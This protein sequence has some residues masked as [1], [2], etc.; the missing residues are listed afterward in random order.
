MSDLCEEPHPDFSGVTCRLPSS[1][2]PTHIPHG[3]VAWDTASPK[4][5]NNQHF[6]IPTRASTAAEAKATVLT[7]AQKLEPAFA[8]VHADA[9]E[10][11]RKAAQ[12]RGDIRPTQAQVLRVVATYG[13]LTAELTH[14]IC[15][16]EEGKP[17]EQ[18]YSTYRSAVSDLSKMTPPLIEDSGLLGKTQA[19]NDA[20]KWQVTEHG[21]SLL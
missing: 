18:V 7:I 3:Y 5:W 14:Q 8:N 11:A 17:A 20:I 4:P 13:P 9:P 15:C 21:K 10:T 12:Q 6:I 19:K 16:E 2:H 1:P